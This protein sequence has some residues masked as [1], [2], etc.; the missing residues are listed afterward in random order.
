MQELNRKRGEQGEQV[1][2]VENEEFLMP[3]SEA[4]PTESKWKQFLAVV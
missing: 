1:P 4:P 2:T 3:R